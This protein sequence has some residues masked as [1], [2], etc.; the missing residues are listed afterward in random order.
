MV[1]TLIFFSSLVYGDILLPTSK[2]FGLLFYDELERTEHR[3]LLKSKF[4]YSTGPV[5][6]DKKLHSALEGLELVDRNKQ[7]YIFGLLNTQV[8]YAYSI[9]NNGETNKNIEQAFQYLGKTATTH[10]LEHYPFEYA[11]LK[12]NLGWIHSVRLTGDRTKNLNR[13]V[14]EYNT[15]LKTL[16]GLDLQNL[17]SSD[18]SVDSLLRTVYFRLAEAYEM[19]YEQLGKTQDI[20][21][22]LV[23]TSKVL[24]SLQG[25][26]TGMVFGRMNRNLSRIYTK[27]GAP[28]DMDSAVTHALK[29]LQ[30][31][32]VES[33]PVQWAEIH[34]ALS[35]LYPHIDSDKKLRGI[36]KAIE[37]TRKSLIGYQ[38]AGEEGLLMQT[39]IDFIKLHLKRTNSTAQENI[40]IT[41]ELLRKFYVST[42]ISDKYY[43][44]AYDSNGW[45]LSEIDQSDWEQESIS[46]R[47]A[48]KDSIKFEGTFS[49]LLKEHLAYLKSNKLP[50]AEFDTALQKSN[51]E[52]N[53]SL[54]NLVMLMNHALKQ[55]ED[56]V[57]K[58]KIIHEIAYYSMQALDYSGDVIW[59]IHARNLLHFGHKLALEKSLDKWVL[60]LANDLVSSSLKVTTEVD[61]VSTIIKVLEKYQSQIDRTKYPYQF[62]QLS[63]TLCAFVNFSFESSSIAKGHYSKGDIEKKIDYCNSAQTLARFE[64]ESILASIALNLGNAYSMKTPDDKYYNLDAAIYNLT[65][66]LEYN[67]TSGLLNNLANAASRKHKLAP[68]DS[69]YL[70]YSIELSRESVSMLN[71]ETQPWSYLRRAGNLAYFLEQDNNWAE[72]LQIYLKLLTA[73]PGLLGEAGDFIQLR[74]TLNKIRGVYE[75][76]AY[77]TLMTGQTD[78]SMKLFESARMVILDIDDQIHKSQIDVTLTNDLIDNQQV[79]D[80]IKRRPSD[81]TDVESAIDSFK[82]NISII[83]DRSSLFK[84]F[85][86]TS[87]NLHPSEIPKVDV[88]RN[89][90]L[91]VPLVSNHGSI[92]LLHRHGKVEPEIISIPRL[93]EDKISNLVDFWAQIYPS[94]DF[95]SDT[96]QKIEAFWEQID[97]IQSQAWESFGFALH[98]MQSALDGV[99]H[100]YLI[101]PAGLESIPIWLAKNP[102]SNRLL[103]EDMSISFIPSYSQFSRSSEGRSRDLTK[104]ELITGW[105]NTDS[106]L[107]HIDLESQL[108]RTS[109]GNGQFRDMSNTPTSKGDTNSLQSSIWHIASHGYFDKLEPNKSG[110]VYPDQSGVLTMG[111][112]RR[113]RL[114][115]NHPVVILSAC[116]TGLTDRTIPGEF[117]GLSGG[118][119]NAGARAVLGTLW[120]VD[121]LPTALL[122]GKF[123]QYYLE[124]KQDIHTALRQ[125][126]LWL[127]NATNSEIHTYL[128]KKALESRANDK[129]NIR[130]L[131]KAA[132]HLKSK[133]NELKYSSP[134]YWGAFY[135]AGV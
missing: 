124:E 61:E 35:K 21:Q 65:K 117:F 56:D 37:H 34:G 106:K 83:D 58:I 44:I 78:N 121:D 23:F 114:F 10:T 93:T 135:V 46:R 71:P 73:V 57:K 17:V 119:L 74:A 7:P 63:F 41:H 60:K 82:R 88:D 42:N 12:L 19:R 110:I 69:Q 95:K 77:A 126:Q 85:N 48:L 113:I 66:G 52:I 104:P 112:L 43:V 51:L 132:Y 105:F 2:N 13:A 86:I 91:L 50:T 6:P 103:V 111:E 122:L 128:K 96:N 101:P 123:Y 133:P 40:Q 39:V 36:D 55:E 18:Q 98:E 120:P 5:S 53:S 129:I 90:V 25:D 97:T 16:S 32:S 107:M 115:S 130:V 131:L 108:I 54:K 20:D 76:A 75:S 99:K 45:G 22:A 116:E 81:V 94:I 80:Y 14:S 28:E 4:Y 30:V 3:E 24:D 33:H 67:R 100:I 102:E 8:A 31:Y 1:L 26:E 62:G 49:M 127:M 9:L 92:F 89:T 109:L 38:A 118:F 87:K 79:S 47:V 68:D 15:A 84:Q 59:G 11:F 72:A 134:A 125:S 70:K 27:R 64:G 29:A